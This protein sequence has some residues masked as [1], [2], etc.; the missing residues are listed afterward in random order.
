LQPAQLPPCLTDGISILRARTPCGTLGVLA[1][2]NLHHFVSQEEVLDEYLSGRKDELQR[3]AKFREEL[4][5]YIVRK[6][7]SC[8]PIDPPLR[9]RAQCPRDAA[10][11]DACVT[12]MGSCSH[13]SSM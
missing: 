9:A 8:M 6:K 12:R 3:L 13:H 7:Y 2:C 11:V 1:H 5:L 10:Y 4:E